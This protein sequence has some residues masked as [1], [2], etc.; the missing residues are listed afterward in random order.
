MQW[1]QYQRRRQDHHSRRGAEKAADRRAE[2]GL[3]DVGSANFA[4]TK[5]TKASCAVV[6]R[7]GRPL[8]FGARGWPSQA[9]LGSALTL[10]KPIA[11]HFREQRGPLRP[12]PPRPP[13]VPSAG[14]FFSQWRHSTAGRAA[15][16]LATPPPTPPMPGLGAAAAGARA[17]ASDQS[18]RG[19]PPR[20]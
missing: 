6:P 2:L 9:R 13:S 16:P 10:V 15:L 19:W 20:R 18:T 14:L 7:S 4:R 1:H 12:P 11:V 17:P 3:E 8:Q 5:G